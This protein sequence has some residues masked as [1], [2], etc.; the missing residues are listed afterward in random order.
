MKTTSWPEIRLLSSKH[1]RHKKLKTTQDV[2]I[3]VYLSIDVQMDLSV[4]Y[5]LWRCAL[6]AQYVMNASRC[7]TSKSKNFLFLIYSL[8]NARV[9][10]LT[11][12][13]VAAYRLHLFSNTRSFILQVQQ[14]TW[15][16]RSDC[17]WK[18]KLDELNQNCSCNSSRDS[19]MSLSDLN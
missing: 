13:N 9:M 18:A 16:M 19:G 11:R 5:K 12:D 14:T 1:L 15:I 3:Y 7:Q 10:S 8:F 17:W 6:P 4:N 2:Y